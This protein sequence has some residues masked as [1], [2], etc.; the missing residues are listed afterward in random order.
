MKLCS[1]EN[2][3]R[4]YYAKE[5][6]RKHYQQFKIHG[7][8][9]KRT[10]YDKNEFIID[11][12]ICWV[13]LYDIECIEVDR[14]KFYTK[15]YKQIYNSDLK[16]HHNGSRYAIAYWNDEDGNQQSIFLHQAIIQLSG[17]IVQPGE[18]IDHKDGD[19]LN[20]LDDNLRI[21]SVAQNRQNSKIQKNNKSGYIGVSWKKPIKK[22]AAYICVNGKN[23][24]LG[25]FSIKEDAARA[26]NIAA[27]KYFGE[28]AV[29]NEV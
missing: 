29:L 5:L 11:G 28:F 14:A 27:I 20:C 26:Y 9:L 15:Y 17:Q 12:D 23:K 24:F 8:V 13:V 7:K 10:K 6:C 4:K 21:C 3:N 19:K 18:E 25:Y 16:W 1:V 2:C 22:W